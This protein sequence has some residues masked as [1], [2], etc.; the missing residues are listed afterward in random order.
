M[1][2]T[3]LTDGTYLVSDM[4]Q[5]QYIKRLYQGYNKAQALKLFRA[6]K[7]QIEQNWFEYLAK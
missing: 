2:C 6:Y 3:K 4:I 7:K 5:G 1:L